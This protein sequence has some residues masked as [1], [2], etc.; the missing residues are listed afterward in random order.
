M[1]LLPAA[2]TPP[3]RS[4]APRS[5]ASLAGRIPAPRRSPQAYGRPPPGAPPGPPAPQPPGRADPERPP[6]PPGHR[7]DR[8]E[9]VIIQRVALAVAAFLLVHRCGESMT[10]FGGIGQFAKAVGQF[11]AAGID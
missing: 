8:R 11:H 4:A 5:P 3:G 10:L 2:S 9:K 6:A 1:P 7:G